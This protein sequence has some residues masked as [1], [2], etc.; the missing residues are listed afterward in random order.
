MK[1]V[2][3]TP[4]T[5]VSAALGIMGLITGVMTATVH[6]IALGAMFLVI[7]YVCNDEETKETYE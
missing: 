5:A 4:L 6:N 3:I 7:G 2:H 1:K